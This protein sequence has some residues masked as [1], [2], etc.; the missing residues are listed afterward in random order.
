[1][2]DSDQQLLATD[3]AAATAAGGDVKDTEEKVEIVCDDVVEELVDIV[4][5]VVD[6]VFV[7]KYRRSFDK[8]FKLLVDSLADKPD[9]SAKFTEI[10]DRHLEQY[11][12]Y[13]KSL[14][15]KELSRWLANDTVS[16]R[17]AYI[18]EQNVDDELSQLQRSVQPLK[19]QMVKKVKTVQ[20]SAKDR[21]ETK[22]R[23]L[24]EL[25]ETLAN[26]TKQYESLRQSLQKKLLKTFNELDSLDVKKLD[27]NC[28]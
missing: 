8:T 28:N 24:T 10:R 1:M 2:S 18:R 15:E 3:T 4:A 12:Q 5:E 21:L 17:L 25:T 13:V 6:N 16:R 27:I 7:A 23:E 20:Q 22:T 19:Q 14:M 9:K 26:E 11:E